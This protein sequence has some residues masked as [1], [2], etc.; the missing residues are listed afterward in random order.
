[1]SSSDQ[2]RTK[3]LDLGKK[4]AAE[5][6]RLADSRTKQSQKDQEAAKYRARAQ[7]ASPSMISS[8][9]RNAGTAEKASLAEG[10]KIADF[11]KK[12][13]DFSKKEG[14]L[15][16]DLSAALKRESTESER[17]RKRQEQK[18]KQAREKERVADRTRVDSQLM[19]SE[20]RLTQQIA[21]IRTPK[22][23]QLRILY[24][25]AGA[26][27]GLRV[28]LEIKRVKAGVRA[29]THRDLVQIEHLSAAT[30]GD[31]LDGLARFRPHVVHFS[32]HADQS[33]LAFDDESGDSEHPVSA[34][35]FARAMGAV[36]Q[37]PVLVV[38][39]ACDSQAQLSELVQI[40]PLAIGMADSVGDQDAMAFS[41]RF[42]TAIAEG[43]SIE[44]S[45]KSAKV[46]MEFD[47]LPDSD[48]PVLETQF[49]VDA[50]DV[51]LVIPPK[52]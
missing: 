19:A 30:P 15:N 16:K 28:D 22:V 25:T 41:A 9:L 38:L 17:E 37:P 50:S 39:N 4:R 7:G 36:D 14:D 21:Q 5:E 35:A 46:Q 23:E 42:Y 29:A 2:I 12:I 33:F 52:E 48:L 45:L 24:L 11:S 3:L 40:V 6:K 1:M 31:L 10:K 18:D 13:A 47:G 8:H 20:N 51:Q 32:G 49:G 26:A 34:G 27:S 44:S 43:Q